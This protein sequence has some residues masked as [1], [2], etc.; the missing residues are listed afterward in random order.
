MKSSFHFHY[1]I[2]T[3]LEN[4][5]PI[6][7][8]YGLSPHAAWLSA[9]ALL[10]TL[11]SLPSGWSLACLHSL[12]LLLCNPHTSSSP[13]SI[14]PTCSAFIPLLFWVFSPLKIWIHH[15]APVF[16]F[17]QKISKSLP[18]SEI[19]LKL[20]PY[21][22]KLLLGNLLIFCWLLQTS[23]PKMKLTSSPPKP[24]HSPKFSYNTM[25]PD[26]HTQCLIVIHSFTE[27]RKILIEHLLYTRH[28]R[29]WQLLETHSCH[30]CL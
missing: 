9:V 22:F 10:P 20:Q 13:S 17:T 2:E 24:A 1:F 6:F 26:T 4:G 5:L 29:L 16:T 27:K 12:W 28:W 3:A 23:A 19:S 21:I 14:L 8:Y 7:S 18:L 30:S 25:L 11:A 15:K